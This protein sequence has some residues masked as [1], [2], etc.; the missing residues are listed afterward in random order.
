MA[1]NECPDV[2]DAEDI[3]VIL[4]YRIENPE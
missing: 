2:S 3:K 4:Y 1:R